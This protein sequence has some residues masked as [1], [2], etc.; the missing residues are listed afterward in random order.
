[1][2][3]LGLAVGK[4]GGALVYPAAFLFVLTI[5]I[6]VHELGHFW[7]GRRC[8]VGVTAFS[9]GFGRELLGWTDRHGTRWKI[10]AIPGLR[11]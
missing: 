7:V 2:E 6:F 1:M 5:V 3:F 8:G 9:I 11:S 4:L 10:C